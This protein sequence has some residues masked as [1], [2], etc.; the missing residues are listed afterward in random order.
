MAM[1]WDSMGIMI[2]KQV[3]N[4]FQLNIAM[5]NRDIV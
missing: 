2:I 4:T 5:E 1:S 3:V